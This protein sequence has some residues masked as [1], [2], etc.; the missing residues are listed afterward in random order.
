MGEEMDSLDKRGTRAGLSC[1]TFGTTGDCNAANCC[2]A[3][4]KEMRDK[5]QLLICLRIPFYA[6]EE[7]ATVTVKTHLQAYLGPKQI[8]FREPDPT[9]AALRAS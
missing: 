7:G 2:Q 9:A 1:V 4:E 8:L 5:L 3:P 6:T